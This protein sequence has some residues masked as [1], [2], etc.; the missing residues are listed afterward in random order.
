[1]DATEALRKVPLFQSIDPN[2]MAMLAR[3]VESHDYKKG[4]V[5]VEAGE[6]GDSL[7]VVERGTLKISLPGKG[8]NKE[9]IL[10]II[11][12]GEFF[13][14]MSLLDGQPR[15]ATVTVQQPAVLLRLAR[16]HFMDWMRERPEICM[17]MLA[18]ISGR[19]REAHTR[20]SSLALLDRVGKVVRVL[21]E[22]ASQ[23]GSSIPEGTWIPRTPT[24][25]ELASMAGTSRETVSRI[26]SDLERQGLVKPKGHGLVLLNEEA[27]AGVL[28]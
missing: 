15:S 26:L 4:T 9:L 14:E 20:Y 17:L 3:K 18:E 13:G 11:G 10:A 6:E 2:E 22:L 28:D 27:L 1:M 7:Y 8:K 5:V 19:L 25:S 23:H 24:Q 12:E 16:G 21:L